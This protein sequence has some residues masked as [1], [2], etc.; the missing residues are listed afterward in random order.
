MGGVVRQGPP[1]LKQDDGARW[2]AEK[3]AKGGALAVGKL[4]TAECEAMCFYFSRRHNMEREPY[5]Q[6]ILQHMM[7]NAGIFPANEETLDAFILHLIAVLAAMDGIAEWNPCL[8]IQE[9]F[10]LD[11][12]SPS[13][14]RFP[15][16]SLEPY[17][18]F[19]LDPKD[20]DDYRWTLKIPT[21][22][23]VAVVSPFAESI[24]AQWK[25]KD[26]VWRTGPTVWNGREDIT[27]RT[28]R[29]GY[30]PLLAGENGKWPLAVQEGGWRTAIRWMTDSVIATG[31]SL[32]IIGC[33]A[34]SLPLCAALKERGIT[35]IHT[36][37]AT[38]ILFGIKGARWKEH[39]V[40][41]QFFNDVWIKPNI[42]EIPNNA[43]L[44]EGGCYW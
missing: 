42:S 27:I 29:S 31:A 5:P 17:Y 10:L 26:A 43:K 37:G 16:R 1:F 25:I 33:G 8:P 21:G 11:E 30:S 3:V 44:V 32:A 12:Y 7:V 18:S 35:A 23:T 6:H 19:H 9:S 20:S 38:Q 41:S 36:G 13:S 4:G 40:I 28:V 22:S 39:P 14:V 34:L 24:T 15:A 2:L